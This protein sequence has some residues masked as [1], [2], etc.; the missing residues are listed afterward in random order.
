VFERFRAASQTQQILIAAGGAL[1]IAL[2]LAV[3]WFAFL[4]TP[5]QMLFSGLR[6]SDAAAIVADLDKR[7]IPYRLSHGGT[8][9]EVPADIVDTT[10]LAVMTSDLP[11]KG[12]VG[13]ELFNKSDMGLTDFAQKINYQRALQGELERTIMS[14]DGVDSARVHLSLGEDRL[15]R[16]DRVPP[17]ASVTIHMARGGTLSAAAAQGI[18]RLV[19]AAV[20]KLDAENVVILDEHG[21]LVGGV[22]AGAPATEA[23]TPDV[24]EARAVEQF[25]AGLVRAGLERAYPL[26]SIAVTIHAD[27]TAEEIAAWNPAARTFALHIVLTPAA[28]LDG[29]AQ[30]T[31]RKLVADAVGKSEGRVDGIDFAAVPAPHTVPAAP[32]PRATAPS[33]P[34]SFAEDDGGVTAEIAFAVML[35]L[36]ILAGFFFAAR[37]LRAS[38]RLTA[39]Q[40]E[41]FVLRLRALLAKEGDGVPSEG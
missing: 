19:A 39:A 3:A 32:A 9:I 14:L 12:T 7:K 2:V 28:P 37:Q 8:A 25:Y 6:A 21:G 26:N 11:L 22:S 24:Q 10:R 41:D 20:P 34:V 29:T 36:V 17:T 1:A 23:A 33:L 31:V 35:V 13:F 40:R 15:F 18:Q 27:A 30:E 4:R 5:Y 16:D 38:R